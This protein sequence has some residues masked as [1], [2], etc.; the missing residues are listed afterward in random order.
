MKFDLIF[1]KWKRLHFIYIF[2]LSI[3][4]KRTKKKI[5]KKWKIYPIL[6]KLK[7]SHFLLASHKKKNKKSKKKKKSKFIH[8]ILKKNQNLILFLVN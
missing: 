7:T 5:K 8:V 1:G 4:Y 6:D 3:T 2:I